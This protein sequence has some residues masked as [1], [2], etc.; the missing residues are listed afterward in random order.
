MDLSVREHSILCN[1][2]LLTAWA[3][4][5]T[6]T[7]ELAFMPTTSPMRTTSPKHPGPIFRKYREASGLKLT[8]LAE[9]VSIDK[10]RLS[11]W[12]QGNADLRD[13]EVERLKEH[14][15]RH[16]WVRISLAN[17]VLLE[18]QSFGK[19]VEVLREE[20]GW[21]QD[22]LGDHI[23]LSR[24]AISKLE[25]SFSSVPSELR[26][27]INVV[28]EPVLKRRVAELHKIPAGLT[29][30]AAERIRDEVQDALAAAARDL[31]EA[32]AEIAKMV[33]SEGDWKA[34][35]KLLV[36]AST[37][38][39]KDYAAAGL[40]LFEER[41]S[42]LSPSDQKWVAEWIDF[43]IFSANQRVPGKTMRLAELAPPK[44]STEMSA[45]KKR[46]TLLGELKSLDR[47]TPEQVEIRKLRAQVQ[48]LTQELDLTKKI[49]AIQKELLAIHKS[50]SGEQ[51]ARIQELEQQVTD[52]R[53]LY[54]AE[55]EAALAHARAEELREKL[56]AREKEGH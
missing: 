12:E 23:D 28:A 37:S 31:A 41:Y 50:E 9:S 22:E 46:M 11:R 53:N 14:I 16:R 38:D 24:S 7:V 5:V 17:R 52:L 54:E 47:E 26:E 55:T 18:P 35:M 20:L 1:T 39:D 48:R 2:I 27:R 51:T 15:Y 56:S 25:Q 30:E 43:R 13:D 8:A 42:T 6:L 19:S 21:T 3:A 36:T 4:I 33:D 10:S 32:T 34:R 40:T 44:P 45:V 29:P 49:A